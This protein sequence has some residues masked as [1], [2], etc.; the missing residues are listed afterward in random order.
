MKVNFKDGYQEVQL[1]TISAGET[2]RMG[3]EVYLKTYSYEAP[4]VCLKTGLTHKFQDDY[5]VRRI[6]LEL[7]EV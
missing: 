1:S 7:V 4:Y 3:D 2:F 5:I 6:N